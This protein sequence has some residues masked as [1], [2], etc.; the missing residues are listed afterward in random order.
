MKKSFLRNSISGL[1]LVSC[2]SITGV[3]SSYAQALRWEGMPENEQAESKNEVAVKSSDRSATLSFPGYRDTGNPEA[4]E[5]RFQEMV[6]N[7]NTN[8]PEQVLDARSVSE[9][10]QG[11]YMR[12]AEEKVQTDSELK[13]VSVKLSEMSP[14]AAQ[15]YHRLEKYN[16]TV[17]WE[18]NGL[19]RHPVNVEDYKA[20]EEWIESCHE[21]ML[22]NP[23]VLASV[24]KKALLPEYPYKEN[25]ESDPDYPRYIQTGNP[26]YDDAVYHESKLKYTEKC[27]QYAPF[28]RKN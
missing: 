14:A 1:L 17:L 11:T 15:A 9:I 3:L 16:L 19:P 18:Q 24:K 7:W 2:I 8:K 13:R 25:P 26:E 10:R 28:S 21:W 27:L 20:Y 5:T 12:A 22:S 6:R 4:D 23:E